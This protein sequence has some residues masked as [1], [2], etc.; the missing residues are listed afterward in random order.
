LLQDHNET[1]QRLAQVEGIG[2][3]TATA[4]VSTV[5]DARV[6]KNGRHFAAFLGLVPRQH[7]S[8]NQQRL[9]GISKHGDT[10]LRTLFVH[11]ARSALHVAHKKTDERNRWAVAVKAR[12]GENIAC[13]ALANKQARTVW[14][15]LAKNERYQKAA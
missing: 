14:D 9:L 12:R 6:F 15:L 11:G 13:V 4:V 10:Y 7:S 3:L 2:L 1:C 5:S 8:G